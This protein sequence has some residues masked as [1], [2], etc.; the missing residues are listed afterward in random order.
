VGRLAYHV[1][2]ALCGGGE[3]GDIAFPGRGA[4]DH[5]AEE[6]HADGCRPGSSRVGSLH[7]SDRVFRARRGTGRASAALGPRTRAANT[8]TRTPALLK[9]LIFGAD[10][11]AMTPTHACK[12][13]RLY[14]Y[15]IAAGLLKGDVRPGVVR[16]VPAAEIESAVV[17]QVRSLVRTPEIIVGTWRAVR[18]QDAAVT[19]SEVSDALRNLDPLWDELFPRGADARPSAAGR[20]R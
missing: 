1:L 11:R 7:G 5:A 18:S 15:Y 13:G 4:E 20:A 2:P 8:R 3:P 10:G 19:E 14:R 6:T 12:R 17:D 16:R 9:G